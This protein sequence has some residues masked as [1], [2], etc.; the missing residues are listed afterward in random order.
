MPATPP[1][2]VRRARLM[3]SDD[4]YVLLVGL[5]SLDVPA[6]LD[7][8]GRAGGRRL[9]VEGGEQQEDREE[10]EPESGEHGPLS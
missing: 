9:G 6:E 8:R 2:A 5:A 3:R 10:G 1:A 7:R 4:P